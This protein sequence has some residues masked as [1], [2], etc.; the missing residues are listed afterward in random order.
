MIHYLFCVWNLGK[1]NYLHD[2]DI[3]FYA[4]I[5]ALLSAPNPDDPLSE[6]IAKHWKSNEAEAVETGT[7]GSPFFH[8]SVANWCKMLKFWRSQSVS[9]HYV[10][11]RN[12]PV[13]TQV[14]LD[15]MTKDGNFLAS[16]KKKMTLNANV[17]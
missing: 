8:I 16:P 11:Q 2:I 17:C 13:C 4:S 3:V 1:Y 6:N 14:V 7:C 15:E 5:Q 9:V 12:G 10:Q